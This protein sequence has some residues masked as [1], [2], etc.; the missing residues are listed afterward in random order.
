M[1]LRTCARTCISTFSDQTCPHT[2]GRLRSLSN[3]TYHVFLSVTFVFTVSLLLLLV[4]L[5]FSLFFVWFFWVFLSWFFSVCV[6]SVPDDVRLLWVLGD[7]DDI[8]RLIFHSLFSSL[9]EIFTVI[10]SKIYSVLLST[11]S[12]LFFVRQT[13]ER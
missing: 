4:P 2:S 3:Y 11:E 10:N 7:V 5:S 6:W 9:E 12:G 8:F 1:F 13:R